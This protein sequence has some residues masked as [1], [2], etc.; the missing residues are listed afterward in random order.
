M[1]RFIIKCFFLGPSFSSNLASTT[2]LSCISMSNRVR[3]A[4]PEIICVNSNNPAF[5]PFSIKT[6]KYSGNCILMILTQKF[7]L[8]YSI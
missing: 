4:I 7:T 1:F 3:K 5:Y 6:I 8:K 2:S